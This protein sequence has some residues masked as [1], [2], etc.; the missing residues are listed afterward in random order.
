MPKESL[1][2]RVK[3]KSYP[4]QSFIFLWA[5][6]I[7]FQC[8][9]SEDKIYS[10]G[11]FTD[12]T[13]ED[14]ILVSESDDSDESFDGSVSFSDDV[15]KPD[16][17]IERKWGDIKGKFEIRKNNLGE[18]WPFEFKDDILILKFDEKSVYHHLYIM[19]LICSLLK[20]CHKKRYNELTDAFEYLSYCLFNCLM[21]NGWVVKMTGAKANKGKIYPKLEEIAKNTRAKM[22]IDEDDFD[23]KNTGDGRLDLIAWHPLCDDR[24]FIPIALAQCGCSPTAWE[25]KQLEASPCSLANVFSFQ[26]PPVNYYFMPHDLWKNSS[27]WDRRDKLSQVVMIDRMRILKLSKY[28]ASDMF[29]I[30]GK[31]GL[32]K[33]RV[34]KEALNYNQ[35]YFD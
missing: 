3:F 28:Y 33:L 1:F 23:D 15:L 27:K 29:N 6:Y 13:E 19:L 22:V 32:M 9:I 7:E 35:D 30:S 11:Y 16:E 18:L 25:H 4:S 34:V 26:H 5:D 21:P 10:S 24:G 2:D 31:K 20:H 12:P 17:K 14:D 8:L